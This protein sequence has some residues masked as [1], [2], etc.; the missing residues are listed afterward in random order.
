MKQ[1]SKSIVLILDNAPF[2]HSV[3]LKNFVSTRTLNIQNSL[4]TNNVVCNTGVENFI[5][6]KSISI[7]PNPTRNILKIANTPANFQ[8]SVY[9]IEGKE[10]FTIA[11]AT[12]IDVSNF[13]AGIYFLKIENPIL[14]YHQMFQIVK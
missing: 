12:Q 8:L 3:A 9:S 2:N 10:I 6:E 1:H 11:D 7:F 5:Q 4:I 14:L 13:S